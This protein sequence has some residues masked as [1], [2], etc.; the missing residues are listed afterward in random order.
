[1]PTYQEL[2][3]DSGLDR[4]DIHALFHHLG[5]YNRAFL[6]THGDEAADPAFAERFT[7]LAA[8]RRAGEPV[9]YLLGEKE[10]YSLTFQVGPGVLI[11][12]PETEL[13]VDLA[14]ERL[15]QG[16]ALVD[17]GT[18]SGIIALTIAHE[19]P[20]ATVTALDVS[21]AALEIARANASRLAPQVR[22][23][24]SDWYSALGHEQFAVIVSNPPYIEQDDPHLQQGDLRFEPR[25][26]LTDEADGLVH[27]RSIINGA[28]PRL[29]AGGWLLFEHG[30][31]Q[32]LA[33]RDLLEAAG[34]DQVQTWQDIAGMD[35]VSG[36]L[37]LA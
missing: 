17:L 24:Q 4:P 1:M 30:F 16:G 2:A 28:R 26:A 31:D 25:S 20:D 27:I 13:L 33:A 37:A 5:G 12:R 19:R 36:G 10:F 23:L 8:R 14:L 32:G 34:F 22:V 35:R 9:A 3:R 21:A 11:P 7:A 15:P 6:I 29:L 18:G